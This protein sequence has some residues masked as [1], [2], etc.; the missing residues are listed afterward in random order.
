MGISRSFIAANVQ[1]MAAAMVNTVARTTCRL[2]NVRA[3]S[4]VMIR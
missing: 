3:M 4:K 1:T 2:R